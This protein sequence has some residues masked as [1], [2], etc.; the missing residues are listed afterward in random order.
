VLGVSDERIRVAVIGAGPSGFYAAEGLLGDS[1]HDF[2]VDLFDRLATPWGLVRAGV[3]PDHPKI[4]S[5]SK[6]FEKTAGLDGFRFHGNV[7]VG[8]DITHADLER[9]FH[10]VIYTTGSSI[11]RDLG[12]PGEDLHGSVSATDFV[13]WYNGHPD[14]ADLE[15]DL[16]H[17]RA[18]VVG[19]GNVALDVAR[20]LMVP[21]AL[22]LETDVADHALASLTDHGIDEVVILGRRGPAEASFTTAELKELETLTDATVVIEGDPDLEIPEDAD[23]RVR[24]N[25]EVIAGYAENTRPTSGRTIVMRFLSSPVE[26][27]GDGRVQGVR[28]VRNELVDGRAK[29]TEDEETM[30]A[31]IV[32]R[33]VGYQGR[34]VPGVPFDEQSGTIPNTD[35]RVSR[36][37]Y[38]AGWV[39]R[40]PS[41]IIGTNKKCANATLAT[42]RADLERADLLE[43]SAGREDFEGLLDPLDVVDQAGWERIDVHERSRGEELG[44]PRV[45][46]TRR[47]EL[48]THATA[49]GV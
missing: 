41:G 46:V 20:M 36:G 22:L 34:E 23:S 43:P 16:S 37:V 7:D 33:S 26:V 31:G 42:L 48:L 14:A 21:E 27:L 40:G 28:V 6:R 2:E 25:L 1:D 9:H 38:A 49:G 18:V 10:A 30:E 11:G 29:A 3:A 15:F 47:E 24:R 13:A 12:I 32:I 19:N 44:R 17:S 45:K 35:G 5:V 39:K 4:K 8:T